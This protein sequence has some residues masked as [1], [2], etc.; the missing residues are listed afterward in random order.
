MKRARNTVF[1]PWRRKKRSPGGRAPAADAAE[2]V[3]DVVADD[4]GDRGDRD[5]LRDRVVVLLGR[6]E[7]GRGHERGLAGERDSRRLARDDEEEEDE[8]VVEEE[9]RHPRPVY[10]GAGRPHIWRM[11]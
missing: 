7:D 1:P 2:P 10:G 4:R 3:A 6:R 5:H 9:L 11:R 8:P